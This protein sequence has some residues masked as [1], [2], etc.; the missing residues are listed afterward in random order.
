MKQLLRI[1]VGILLLLVAG[2]CV[3]GF[4]ASFEPGRDP[5]HVT[6][7]AYGVVGIGCL[8]AAGWLILR[9]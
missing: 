4:L 6:K 5:W 2:F 1:V 7:A 3:F 9:R 8:T